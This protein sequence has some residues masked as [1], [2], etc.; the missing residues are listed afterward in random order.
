MDVL[1]CYR[2]GRHI[3][4]HRFEMVRLHRRVASRCLKTASY[5]GTRR[6][7]VFRCTWLR[8]AEMRWQIG[9]TWHPWTSTVQLQLTTCLYVHTFLYTHRHGDKYK[10]VMS[11][12]MHLPL[13]VRRSAEHKQ[14]TYFQQLYNIVRTVK[15]TCYINKFW[16]YL[17]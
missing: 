8:K 15:Q 14:K 17:V 1:W 5:N 7:R 11:S 4:E 12:G 3:S 16:Y 6:L 9:H 10:Y 13:S 2:D